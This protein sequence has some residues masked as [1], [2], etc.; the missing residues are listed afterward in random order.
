MKNKVIPVRNYIIAT[1]ISI[2]TIMILVLSVS[3]YNKQKEYQN[4]SNAI[5]GFL[6]EIKTEELENFIIDNRDAM[7]Y[8]SNS[9][10]SNNKVQN[11]VK[12]IINKNDYSK[13]IVYLNLKDLKDEFYADFATKYFAPELSN[14]SLLSDSLIIIKD[15]KVVRIM[16][17]TE[18]NVSELKEYIETHFYGEK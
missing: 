18:E 17:I 2:V 16:N 14:T 1:I 12:K 6:S 5:M 3:Y 4:E 10:I 11:K 15:E 9:D 13:E 8:I 7:I